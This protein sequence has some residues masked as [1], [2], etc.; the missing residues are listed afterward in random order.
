[1]RGVALLEELWLG[2]VALDLAHGAGTST[3]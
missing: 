2:L 1:L 3:T